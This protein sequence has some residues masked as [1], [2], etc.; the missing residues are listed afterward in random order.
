MAEPA[1]GALRCARLCAVVVACLG[2][3]LAG[4]AV[5]GG[6]IP[7]VGAPLVATPVLALVAL[8][9]TRRERG[10]GA[11]FAV[12]TAVEAALHALFHLAG[13]V[14]DGV[15]ANA[16]LTGHAAHGVP[17]APAGPVIGAGGPEHLAH[18]G[19]GAAI[20]AGAMLDP[21]SLLPTGPMAAAHLVA[22]ALTAVV[23]GWGDRSLWALARRLLPVLPGPAAPPCPP[24]AGGRPVAVPGPL[25]PLGLP[26]TAPVRGPPMAWA[27]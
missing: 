13:H 6:G 14:P 15:G 8:W 22:I 5:G 11:L 25:R 2:L 10:V 9:F 18:A 26:R 21:A 17:R 19:H 27:A 16:L 4:H 24:R 1:R 23:L 12:L 20:H 3:A 7:P